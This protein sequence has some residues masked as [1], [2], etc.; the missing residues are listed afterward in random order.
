MFTYMSW[1]VIGYGLAALLVHLFHRRYMRNERKDAS[2][3]HYIL[4][5]RNHEHQ[6]EW[7]I[8]ALS[9]YARLRGECIRVTILDEAS[10]DDTQAILS[11]LYNEAGISLNVMELPES[12]EEVFS[13][14]SESAELERELDRSR[15]LTGDV[16]S[17]RDEASDI[18]SPAGKVGYLGNDIDSCKERASNIGSCSDSISGYG[19]L[20]QLV[21]I[22]LR[23]PQEAN[24]IPYV[25]SRI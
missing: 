15:E 13:R 22:D 6:L 25:H 11:R 8:R 3:S 4:V 10:R 9:W 1:I 21:Y 16:G 5:T 23:V 19:D 18:T 17:V 2:E 14:Y 24:K 7:Y 20:E 12:A